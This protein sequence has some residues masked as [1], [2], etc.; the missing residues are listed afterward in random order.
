MEWAED[1]L[2]LMSGEAP[3]GIGYLVVDVGGEDAAALQACRA[4]EI[5]GHRRLSAE[6]PTRPFRS[7]PTVSDDGGWGFCGPC[8]ELRKAFFVSLYLFFVEVVVGLVS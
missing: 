6:L 1:Y 3:G 5:T 8:L 7:A 4:P 2:S